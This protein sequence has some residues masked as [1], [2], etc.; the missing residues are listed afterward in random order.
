MKR[1][2]AIGLTLIPLAGALAQ[3]RKG[4]F[5]EG[6]SVFAGGAWSRY[7]GVPGLTTFPEMGPFMASRAGTSAGFLW[8]YRFGRRFILDIG[9]QY[10]R[11]GA[12]VDWKFYDDLLGSWRYDLDVISNPIT[13]RYK[14]WPKSSPY[15]LAGYELSLIVGHSL[16][17]RWPLTENIKT[18][19]KSDS[20]DLDFGLIAGAGA[21]IALGKWAF[22]SE[23]RYCRGLLDISKGTGT[24]ES[25]PV[26]TTRA[27]MVLAGVRFKF[28][29]TAAGP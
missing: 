14:P 15:I 9:L 7:S 26:I 6:V 29:R 22:F 20:Y 3:E 4:P 5:I 1:L 23:F 17:D 11:K 28:K 2:I 19:L 12:N 21:E 18:K 10:A 27:L 25:Y 16:A 24:L 13:I 8:Q